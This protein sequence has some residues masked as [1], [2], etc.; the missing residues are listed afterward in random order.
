[1][2]GLLQRILD[3]FQL[4]RSVVIR[5][6]NI[7]PMEF[8]NRGQISL[9]DFGA[10]GQL[11]RPTIGDFASQQFFDP[12][13]RI[14]FHD[15]Q[16]VVQVQTEA[17]QFIVN[18]LLRTAVTHNAFTGEDLHVDNGAFGALI[19]PQGSVFHIACLFAKDSAQEL[20]FRCQCRFTFRCDLAHQRV[21]RFNFSAH[22]DD[23][24]LVQTIELLLAQI[25]N[26]ARN[27]FRPKLGVPGHHDQFFNMDRGVAVIS[28]HTLTDQNR[29]FEVVAIPR[30]ERDQHVLAQSQL[31]QVGGGTVRD[32]IALG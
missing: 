28:H 2:A 27:F 3:T 17:L 16:L 13:K 10:L 25:W 20:F 11:L 7:E 9:V 1:M 30:H 23:A 21:A 24:G 12:V 19:D 5:W 14:G 15:A 6:T 29:V 26:V 31:T 18:D 22:I 8:F 4:A 32:D